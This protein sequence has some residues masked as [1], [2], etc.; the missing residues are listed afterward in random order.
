ML[1]L[2]L[3]E[4]RS[5][6]SA[7]IGYVVVLSFLALTGLFLWVF[8]GSWN[9]LDGGMAT[10]EPFFIWAPWVLVFL[11]PAITMRSFAEERRSGT[12]ELLLTRPLGEGAIVWAKF[13]GAT[14]VLVAALLPT[15]AYALVVHAL[16]EPLGNLDWGATW[17]SYAGLLLLGMALIGIGLLMSSLTVNPLVAFLSAL[18]ASVVAY[19]GFTALASFDCLGNWDYAFSRL[20]MEAH[21]RGMSRG[22]I[23]SQDLGYFGAWIAVMGLATR[24]SLASRKG[25]IR[26]DGLQFLLG[27]AVT[28]AVLA[29]F[30]VFPWSLDWTAEGRHTLSPATVKML[31]SMEEEVSVT[32]YLSGTYPADWQR[33]ERSIRDKFEEFAVRSGGKF[34]YQFEDIYAT[35][36][37]QTIGE[38]ENKL[39]ELGLRFTRIGFQEQGVKAFKT[40]WPAAMVYAKG[41]EYPVQFFKSEMPEPSAEMIQG[42]INSVEFELA[43][44]LRKAL[45]PETPKIAVLEGHGELLPM[46]MA[47]LTASLA[48]NY[49]VTR[50]RIDEKVGALS[51]YTEGVRYRK[52][53][54]DLVIVAKPD[55]MFS[56]KDQV[57]LDQ[58]IMNGGKVL[59]LVDPI[60]VNL[61]SLSKN[62]VTEGVTRELGLYDLL[63]QYGAKLNRNLVIDLQCAPIMLDAGPSGNQRQ[64]EMFSWYFAP[65]VI[66]QG[67]SHPVTT[68]LDPIHFDFCSRVDTVTAAGDVRKTVLLSSSDRSREYKAPVRVSSSIVTLRPD[69]FDAPQSES[70]PLAVLLEGTFRSAFEDRLPAA[71]LQDSSFAFRSESAPTAMVVVGDGDLARNRTRQGPEGWQPLPLGFDRYAGR[72]IY[73]NKDFLLNTV[74]YLLDDE[75]LISVRSRAIEL[76]ALNAERVRTERNAW[77]LIAVALPMALVATLGWIFIRLRR[78]R[79]SL[80]PLN[81]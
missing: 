38:N 59:W 6:F 49:E 19:V 14:S 3:K 26:E 42:S 68:N 8:P 76:R 65:V 24:W 52:N 1:A 58:F 9:I 36:D 45:R 11:V 25:R 33:L 48:E 56:D 27:T 64:M 16:G 72:V 30:T 21:Y 53:R 23:S 63:F 17:G 15:L 74:N 79:Y 69:Y 70:Q 57:L 71:L 62:Q 67:I 37:A 81:A 10:L 35:E 44:V 43:S 20:G 75:A 29:L 13:I 18:L 54:F 7:L 61:D 4:F 73:D 80:K 31:E 40:V 22:W 60:D 41:K 55:S 5:F 39:W 46:E 2:V 66:P 34:R 32:C 77:Q 12:L 50:V 78:K 51:E 47:D 28:G